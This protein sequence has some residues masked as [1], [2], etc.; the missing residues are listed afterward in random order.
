MENHE[1][2]KWIKTAPWPYVPGSAESFINHML[3]KIAAG[4]TYVWAITDKTTDEFLGL[5][6]YGVKESHKASRGFWL[7]Q[8]AWNKGYM[9]E[10]TTATLE[11]IFTQTP[12]T[13]VEAFNVQSNA[14]SRNVKLKNGF[15]FTE[16]R[17]REPK[18]GKAQDAV[19]EYYHLTK[20]DWLTLKQSQ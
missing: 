20:A 11:Y 12:I 13:L 2:N 6:E 15:K 16:N 8:E 18:P 3:S 14:G 1:V 10:A 5:I 19:C 7:K 4:K 9:Q 17:H